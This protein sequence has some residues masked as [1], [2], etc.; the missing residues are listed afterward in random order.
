MTTTTTMMF[1]ILYDANMVV[2]KTKQIHIILVNKILLHVFV[3][4]HTVQT[5]AFRN[6]ILPIIF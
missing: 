5:W 6:N 2:N 3:Y 1:I 4:S